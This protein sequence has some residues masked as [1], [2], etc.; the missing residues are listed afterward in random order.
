MP[1]VDEALSADA[2][3]EVLLSAAAG[4]EDAEAAGS[5]VAALP[6]PVRVRRVTVSTVLISF[7]FMDQISSCP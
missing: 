5:A 3:A 6:Q 2:A 1:A 4:A 7:L